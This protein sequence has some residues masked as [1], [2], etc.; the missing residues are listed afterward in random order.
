MKNIFKVMVALLIINSIYGAG[1]HDHA[2]DHDHSHEQKNKKNKNEKSHE[3]H[4]HSGHDDHSEH[5]DHSGHDHG[6]GGGK[7]I[8]ENKAITKVDEKKGFMLSNKAIQNLK[9]QLL[10]IHSDEVT[11]DESQIVKVKDSIGVYR[12]RGGFFKFVKCSKIRRDKVNKKITL[13]L[14]DYNFGDQVVTNG[15]SLLRV[16]DIY[17]TDKSEYG[18]AH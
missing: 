13:K 16:T 18:H 9:L 12:F 1:D 5:D 2:H 4:D 7:A 8:G 10:N 6:H 3:G 14:T 11:L 17:S 15:I